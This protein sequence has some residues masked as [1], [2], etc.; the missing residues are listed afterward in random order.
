MS[1]TIDEATSTASQIA[2][3][4][5]SGLS[6]FADF[7]LSGAA[8][9][10]S[11]Y[12]GEPISGFTQAVAIGFII[13]KAIPIFVF[14]SAI[15]LFATKEWDVSAIVGVVGVGIYGFFLDPTFGEIYGTVA[16]GPHQIWNTVTFLA[17]N[18]PAQLFMIGTAISVFVLLSFLMW[19][20]F[21]YMLWGLSATFRNRPIFSQSSGKAHAVLFTAY[22]MLYLTF[23]SAAM[24]FN[25]VVILAVG[26]MIRRSIKRRGF[27][28]TTRM[29][30][31]LTKNEV[32]NDGT[33]R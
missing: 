4:F 21:N 30:S 11:Q 14:V 23:G 24:A 28:V 9:A 19:Y 26:I 3:W 16:Q 8:E 18:E 7:G 31:N 6:T 22:W 32:Q 17:N 29:K 27:E 15:V 20:G 1:K 12:G 13:L 10:I 5:Y 25:H 33:T 2:D